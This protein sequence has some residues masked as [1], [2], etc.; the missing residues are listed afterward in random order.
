[1]NRLLLTASFLCAAALAQESA[2]AQVE[3]IKG[4]EQRGAPRVKPVDPTEAKSAQSV[5]QQAQP[6]AQPVKA[7][8]Q[9]GQ[10]VEQK[11]KPMSSEAQPVPPPPSSGAQAAGQE[12]KA[13]GQDAKAAGQDA[14]QEAKAS[15]QDAKAAGQDAKAA[16][17]EAKAAGQEAK[18]VEQTPP[19]SVASAAKGAKPVEQQATAA[20]QG[21]KG[22]EQAA[23]AAGQGGKP[24]EQHAAASAA[25]EGA[26]PVPPPPPQGVGQAH[27]VKPAAAGGV[28]PVTG[29]AGLDADKIRNLE[30]ALQAKPQEGPVD[31]KKLRAAAKLLGDP[32]PGPEPKPVEKTD[33]R[34]MLNEFKLP[35]GS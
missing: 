16:G 22:V 14:G 23:K 10:A 13:A 17:Q 21:G 5:P 1:M 24:V 26:K 12:A 27:G 30:A 7:A 34:S 2:P 18:P 3:G 31:A 6:V 20:G 15:G 9:K 32:R 29:V 28:R 25:Q 8:P 33:A 4:V 35:E 11:A 19:P